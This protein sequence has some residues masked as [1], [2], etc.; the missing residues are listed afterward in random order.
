MSHDEI[1]N[2]LDSENY[3]IITPL[4]LE[5][6]REIV[7]S[8]LPEDS[9][10]LFDEAQVNF[11]KDNKKVQDAVKYIK[12]RRLDTAINRPDA[13]YLSLKDKFQS[14]RLVIPFKDEN[15]KIVFFQT[16]KIFEW[17]EK[18]NYLSK[19]NS[20][21]TLYGID[22]VDVDMDTVFLFEGPID[23][24]FV[25]NGI[26]VAG[27]NKGHFTF[28]KSQQ[29]QLQSLRLFEKIW[30]LDSQ[31]I[32]QTAREKTLSLLE[33]GETVFIWPKVWGEKYKDFNEMCIARGGNSI[34]PEA[35]KK[36]SF[37]G[38]GAVVKFKMMFSSLRD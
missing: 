29:L 23:A 15:G 28:T 17:D 24:F 20:D 38:M 9:I 3:D 37:Q 14:D 11:Y 4:E 27:I 35:I 31:W 6:K 8:T 30:V 16:R 13:L 7:V 36:H 21:K 32:D 25:K 5:Q 10:N 18:P 22:K 12:S 1:K 19:L 2:S 33:A 26:G 34:S